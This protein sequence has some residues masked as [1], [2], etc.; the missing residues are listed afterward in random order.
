M[1]PSS[2]N[3]EGN[4]SRGPRQ[5]K[6][7]VLNWWQ[8][9]L[10][11]GLG[12]VFSAGLPALG[13]VANKTDKG[14]KALDVMLWDVFFWGLLAAWLTA[15]IIGSFFEEEHPYEPFFRG[16]GLPALVLG[17]VS[18]FLLVDQVGINTNR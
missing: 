3:T 17:L 18:G 6:R 11:S 16:L 8:K 15:I 1:E 4:G 5:S 12:G 13:R 14:Q 9:A 7:K 2:E 10:L